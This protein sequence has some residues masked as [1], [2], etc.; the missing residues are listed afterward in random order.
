MN[1]LMISVIAALVLSMSGMALAQDG[2]PGPGNKGQRP[3]RGMQSPPR[4]MVENVLRAIK[5]L[6]LSDEQ[7]EGIWATAHELKGELRPLMMEMH[8][9]QKQLREMIVSGNI[10]QQAV[11]ALAKKEGNLT[12][13]RILLSS[14]AVANILGQLTDEQ[15]AQLETKAAERKA[16]G[17]RKHGKRK[18]G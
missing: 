10:D 11:A 7:K 8:N 2:A 1:K 17:A 5:R 4:N 16:K 14:K 15:K 6:D 3:H 12:E 9:G 13:Q 18:S